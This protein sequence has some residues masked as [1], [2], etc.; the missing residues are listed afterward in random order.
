MRRLGGHGIVK[1]RRCSQICCI[2]LLN[3]QFAMAAKNRGCNFAFRFCSRS[4][5]TERRHAGKL[6]IPADR[7]S[8]RCSDGDADPGKAARPNADQNARCGTAVH[9]LGDHRDQALGMAAADEFI[10]LGD[11][12]ALPVEQSGGAGG[13]GSIERQEHMRN[14]GPKQPNAASPEN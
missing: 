6:G 4:D 9:Q 11:A 7:K 1:L 13:A 12:L 5:Q 2:K 14:D 8:V 3:E 10:G